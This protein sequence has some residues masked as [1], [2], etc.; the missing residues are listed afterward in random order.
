ML[1]LDEDRE[2]IVYPSWAKLPY[3]WDR[4][5]GLLWN[6]KKSGFLTPASYGGY[7][8]ASPRLDYLDGPAGGG[9]IVVNKPPEERWLGRFVLGSHANLRV[10]GGRALAPGDPFGGLVKYVEPFDN[11]PEVQFGL[12]RRP[13]LYLCGATPEHAK[14]AGTSVFWLAS[15]EKRQRAA[16]NLAELPTWAQ[17]FG[18]TVTELSNLPAQLQAETADWFRQPSEFDNVWFQ[19]AGGDQSA[20]FH[21]AVLLWVALHARSVVK[22]LWAM[23][24]VAQI[25]GHPLFRKTW[26]RR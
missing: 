25:E 17:A 20:G 18:L 9:V 22:R 11:P 3:A 15:L 4:L 2:F 8:V 26:H 1:L 6:P 24:L 7:P 16:A 21:F 12:R 5:P 13:K 10:P 14:S 23:H 19:V